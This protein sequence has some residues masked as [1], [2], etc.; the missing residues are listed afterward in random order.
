MHYESFPIADEISA[1]RCVSKRAHASSAGRK[2]RDGSALPITIMSLNLTVAPTG[3][4]T[5][6]IDGGLT[7]TGGGV[8]VNGLSSAAGTLAPVGGLQKVGGTDALGRWTGVQLAWASA[9]ERAKILMRT[10]FQQYPED[11]GLLVFEQQFPS[12][13]NST[14]ASPKFH[15]CFYEPGDAEA[16]TAPAGCSTTPRASTL[17]PTFDRATS[18]E[19]PCFSYHGIFPQMKECTVGTYVES[20]QGGVPLVMYNRTDASLPMVVFS[21]LDWPKAQHVAT[22]KTTIGIGVKATVTS[23][24]AGWSHRSILSAG[25]GIGAGM[26]TWGDRMIRHAG[27]PRVDHRYRD[28]VHATIGFW[29]DNGG[30]Y[31]YATGSKETY[32]EVLPKV[33]A[34]H[35]S[36]GVRFGHWQFDS[37]FYPK[38]GGVD[39]GGGGGGVT[40]WTAMPSVFPAGMAAIQ[41]RLNLPIVMHNRQWSPKSDYIHDKSLPFE[42]LSGPDWTIP[43]DPEGFFGWFFT[44][45]Q[46]WGL[47]M[48]EQDWMCKEYDGTAA[49]QTNISLADD[50][51]RGMANGA[52]KSGRTVQYCMP[53][54]HDVLSAAAYPAVTNTRA[55]GDYFHADHQ[56]AIGG[57]SLFYDALNI[58][59]FKDGFYSSTH[60]QVG[61]QTVGPETHPDRE[62]IMATLS[63]AM[64]GPMDGINLLNASRVNATC[65]A[66]GFVLKPDAP[67]KTVDECFRTGE[68]PSKCFVYAT[69]SDVHGVGRVHYVFS[70]DD[71]PLTPRLIGID[72][73]DVAKYILVD[74]Y[75]KALTPLRTSQALPASY[76]DT[77]YAMAVPVLAGGWVLLGEMREKYVPLS[78]LRFEQVSASNVTLDV[79]VIGAPF[80]TVTVCA[81][82]A[83]QLEQALVCKPV[84]FGIAGGWKLL[85]FGA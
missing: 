24:P 82:K 60:K 56:W 59:P 81:T 57:T 38:D 66:D 51:L 16:P 2:G 15:S 65:R 74:W 73:A 77:R 23:I 5:I 11:P 20:H 63:A 64:V 78:T 21:P 83:A 37:W 8:K 44:Q 29:T 71:R 28:T 18:G 61:G 70:N 53:Y 34:Y 50:W 41:T 69:H 52:A 26:M 10:T 72:A 3:H 43:A 17:F 22:D 31:H 84:S 54:A 76:E 79:H 39:P 19:L 9:S 47:A 12:T 48:Y 62:T 46:G 80:E 25:K 75:T 32:E 30:Y 14:S 35:D 55:T 7:L 13:L 40:N 33:K 42:W 4:F 67:I 58:L 49:L 1:A 45:Q 27:K 6:V 36:I 85:R 68:D